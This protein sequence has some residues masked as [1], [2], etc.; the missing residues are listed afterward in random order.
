MRGFAADGGSVFYISHKL[1]EVKEIADRI[2]PSIIGGRGFIVI[3]IVILGRWTVLGVAAG[4]FL[5]GML[6]A[7]KLNLPQISD[8]PIHLLG[9]LP[10]IV[11][12]L[13]L[14]ASARMRSNAPRTL[15]T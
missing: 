6:D 7:L 12:V 9:G 1:N 10:W 5:M 4:A 15:V 8:I 14:I 3:A 2:V 13:M 11:V